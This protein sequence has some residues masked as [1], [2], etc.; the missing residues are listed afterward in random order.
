[1]HHVCVGSWLCVV[2]AIFMH[3][4]CWSYFC[5]HFAKGS[6]CIRALNACGMVV[7]RH[8]LSMADISLVEFSSAQYMR[9]ACTVFFVHVLCDV[10]VFS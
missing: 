6:A 9:D 4:S 2:F 7:V 5:I 3:D 1:M 8:A 10:V